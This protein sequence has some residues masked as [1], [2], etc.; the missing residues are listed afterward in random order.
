MLDR[1]EHPLR[2]LVDVYYVVQRCATQGVLSD[3]RKGLLVVVLCEP[4]LIDQRAEVLEER[5]HPPSL[6]EPTGSPLLGMR[7][8][9]IANGDRGR[10]GK[11]NGERIA[12]SDRR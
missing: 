10:L 2:D 9:V 11:T 7:T 4:G 5:D 3:R 1:F 6:T 8:Q 12:N